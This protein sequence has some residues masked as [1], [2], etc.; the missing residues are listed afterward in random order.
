MTMEVS[1]NRCGRL[2]SPSLVEG[3]DKYVCPECWNVHHSG[4]GT[5][6]MTE[7]IALIVGGLAVLLIVLLV[8]SGALVIDL[9]I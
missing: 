4:D 9:P 5:P 6:A 1:C 7:G 3:V 2:H 8:A